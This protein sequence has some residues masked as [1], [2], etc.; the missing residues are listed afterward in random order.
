MN[1]PKAS[2]S[3]LASVVLAFGVSAQAAPPAAQVFVDGVSIGSVSWTPDP[4]LAGGYVTAQTFFLGSDVKVGEAF[5]AP[6]TGSTGSGWE[7]GYG[8][9]FTVTGA[10]QRTLK[11]VYDL[12]FASALAAPLSANS[13]LV[14]TLLDATGGGVQLSAPAGG[15]VQQ[16]TLQPGVGNNAGLSVGGGF[17]GPATGVTGQPFAYGAFNA[18]GAFGNGTFSGLTVVAE[19]TLK[20]GSSAVSLDGLVSVTAVPEPQTYAMLALG[21]LVMGITI[22]GR[23]RG[24]LRS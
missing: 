16:V 13:S 10:A 22:H 7:F 17:T 12:P 15:F 20:P 14:G 5:F 23:G 4:N 9:G 6:T 8:L 24:R 18:N 1:F 3:L 2:N 21:L 19:F 11:V